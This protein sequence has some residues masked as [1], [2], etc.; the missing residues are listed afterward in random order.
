[1]RLA[2]LQG[3]VLC[4]FALRIGMPAALSLP[5][6]AAVPGQT[7]TAAFSL[8]AEGQPISGIEFDV[9]W[10]PLLE[11][12]FVAGGGVP[13]SSKFLYSV[14]PATK[15][16]RFLFAGTDA[17]L[18]PDGDLLRLFIPVSSAATSGTAAITV[19]NAVATSP[20]GQ[21]LPVQP[22]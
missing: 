13:H 2:S 10:D 1:M 11:I 7:L 14:S 20:D 9:A 15:S 8:S 3:V 5:D 12:Q 4:L 22:M 16:I 6:N 17:G 21:S 19:S 18:L